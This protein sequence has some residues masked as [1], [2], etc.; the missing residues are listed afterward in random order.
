[1]VNPPQNPIPKKIFKLFESSSLSSNP[2]M[3]K[4]RIILP[5]ILTINVPKGKYIGKILEARSDK[6]YLNPPPI[7]APIIT[8]M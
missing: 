7:P 4:P 3:R 6:K 5:R 1:M 8:R 2:K